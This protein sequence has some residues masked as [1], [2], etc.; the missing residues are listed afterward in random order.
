MRGGGGRISR[1]SLLSKSTSGCEIGMALR[2]YQSPL[3]FLLREAKGSLIAA[4]NE[5]SE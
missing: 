3:V 2:R 5:T 1:K 4:L